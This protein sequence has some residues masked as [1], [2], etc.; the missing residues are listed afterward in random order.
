MRQPYFTYYTAC[1]V[2]RGLT[3]YMTSNDWWAESYVHVF[4]EGI[5]V[6]TAQV[7]DPDGEVKVASVETI[8]TQS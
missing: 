5:I 8:G 7:W 3:E 4:V 2:L 6:G 1:V